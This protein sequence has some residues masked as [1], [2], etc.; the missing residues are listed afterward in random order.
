MGVG[1]GCVTVSEAVGTVHGGQSYG[2][3]FQLLPRVPL[4]FVHLL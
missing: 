3:L 2:S 4:L 1:G